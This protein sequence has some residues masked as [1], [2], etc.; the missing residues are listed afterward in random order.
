MYLRYGEKKIDGTWNGMIGELTR[1]VRNKSKLGDKCGSQEIPV[2]PQCLDE[3][4][5]IHASQGDL[6]SL[7]SGSEKKLVIYFLRGIRVTL[8]PKN[9]DGVG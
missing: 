6:V 3:M 4:F 2:H 5:R 8:S 9:V 7:K 1:R